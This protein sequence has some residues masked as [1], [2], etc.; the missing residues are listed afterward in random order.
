MLKFK[1]SKIGIN[2]ADAKLIKKEQEILLKAIEAY[3][4]L[5]LANE[6]FKINQSNLAMLERQVETDQCKIRT[7]SNYFSRFITIRS[8][9]S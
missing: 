5:I 9:A 4:G 1:K 6:K 8:F 2:L 3:S 7:W